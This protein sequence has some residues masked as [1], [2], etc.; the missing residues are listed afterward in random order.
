[1]SRGKRY[2]GERQLNMK[3]V[4]GVIVVVILIIL[5]I[6]GIK[7]IL[8][9]D[10]NALASK[11]IEMAYYPVFTNGNWGVINTKGETVLEPAYAEMIM[12]PNKSKPVFVCIYDVNYVDGSYKTKVVN[13]KNEELFSNYQNINT[14]QNHDENNNL[15]IEESCLKVQSEGKYGLIN[16]DGTLILP[17]E[18][19]SIAPIAGIRNSL[20]I[21][22][23]GKT[24][25]ADT[26]GKIIVPAE[27]AEVSALTS[28]YQNGYIVK[29]AENKFGIIGSDGSTVLECVYAGIKNATDN[30]MYVVNNNGT[31]QVILKDGTAFLDGKVD[32]T[33]E[34]NGTN[35]VV[36]NSG[37]YG[38]YNIETD[39][40]IPVEYEFLTHAFDDKYIAKKQGKY[41]VINLN[42]EV[43]VQ[44]EYEDIKYNKQTDYLKAQASDGSYAYIS[45]N[46]EVKV[47]AGE[48]TILNG[49]IKLVVN[50]EVKYYD[51]KLDERT[52][53][54]IYTANTLFIK[55]ENGKYGF[56]DKNG[57]VVVEC[58]YEDAREQNDYG[59]S[60][61]KQNGKWGTIDQYGNVVI[62]PLY[63][64]KDENEIDFIGKWHASADKNANYF[65]DV[66]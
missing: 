59:F 9:A 64:L 20:I 31:W 26:N 56:T 6:V 43:L 5:F 42:N 10:K 66:Q 54:D 14:I 27:Y 7:K 49:G 48:E 38:I 22:K 40:K 60:A 15:W 19:D 55:K 51:F 17:C 34:I 2:N 12:I 23:E 24:G 25:L 16:L 33:T 53:K 21:K 65:T 41:G 44:F 13:E 37:K 46:L 47:K 62:A 32:N 50:G 29:N 28:N 35:I 11:N 57:K 58:K 18:Y 1:M 8:K 39:L 36:N 4:V 63:T 30:N 45:R 52:N 3:K 61:I